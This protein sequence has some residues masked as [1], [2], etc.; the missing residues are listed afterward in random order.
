MTEAIVVELGQ[1]PM[2]RDLAE[3]TLREIMTKAT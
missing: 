3:Q 1:S 2:F